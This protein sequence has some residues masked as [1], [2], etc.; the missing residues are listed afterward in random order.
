MIEW[1]DVTGYSQGDKERRPTAWRA[2]IASGF[3]I[4]VVSSHIYHK[5][6]WVVHCAPWFDTT[7]IPG[8]IEEWNKDAAQ[9]EALRM[10]RE[11]LAPIYKALDFAVGTI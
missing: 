8:S 3:S 4:S 7:P 11:K 2:V 5:G 1:K 6:K 9:Q 10:V